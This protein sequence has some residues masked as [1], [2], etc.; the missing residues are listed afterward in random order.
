MFLLKCSHAKPLIYRT[1]NY[2]GKKSLT[3]GLKSAGNQ[4]LNMINQDNICDRDSEIHSKD[5]AF[6]SMWIPVSKMD[7]LL[8]WAVKI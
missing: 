2:S 4:D 8:S 3:E 1:E 6:F 5:T 7:V